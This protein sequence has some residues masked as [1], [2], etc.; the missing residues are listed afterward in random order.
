MSYIIVRKA[1]GKKIMKDLNLLFQSLWRDL[2]TRLLPYQGSALPAAL[3]RHIGHYRSF[4]QK[5][6]R[7]SI[8]NVETIVLLLTLQYDV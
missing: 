1:L 7:I 4:M 8:P 6:P 3:H 2:N 5:N